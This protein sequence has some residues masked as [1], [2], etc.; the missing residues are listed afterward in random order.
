MDILSEM[1]GARRRIL[2]RLWKDVTRLL[3]MK[4]FWLRTKMRRS[5]PA[6]PET[7]RYHLRRGAFGRSMEH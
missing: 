3:T 2:Q 4:P 6:R 7:A 5:T 1:A